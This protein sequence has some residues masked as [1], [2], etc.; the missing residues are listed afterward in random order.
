MRTEALCACRRMFDSQNRKMDIAKEVVRKRPHAAKEEG[1]A[2]E[3]EAAPAEEES[4]AGEEL[5]PDE[6]ELGL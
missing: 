2:G 3:Q 6:D 1:V 4:D 5:E